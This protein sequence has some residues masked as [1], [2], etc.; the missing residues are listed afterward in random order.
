MISSVKLSDL[1]DMSQLKYIQDR[2]KPFIHGLAEKY[3]RAGKVQKFPFEVKTANANYI[4]FKNEAEVDLS[5]TPATLGHIAFF[6]EYTRQ[7]DQCPMSSKE[8]WEFFRRQPSFWAFNPNK[9]KNQKIDKTKK[10]PLQSVKPKH[11][12]FLFETACV[13]FKD[14]TFDPLD[15]TNHDNSLSY[16]F[17]KSLVK[18]GLDLCGLRLI[19]LDEQQR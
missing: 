4:E 17:K 18:N 6:A 12:Q 8:S 11:N 13:V 1:L 2:Y 5:L 9:P 16:F 10:N 3:F 14:I 7:D 19:Y 15:E